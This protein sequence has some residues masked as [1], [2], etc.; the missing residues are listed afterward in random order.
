[1]LTI[2]L[3]YEGTVGEERSEQSKKGSPH[4]PHH[5]DGFITVMFVW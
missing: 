3:A 5:L 2:R 4:P 1:M